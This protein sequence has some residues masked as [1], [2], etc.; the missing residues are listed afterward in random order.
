M[1]NILFTE[2]FVEKFDKIVESDPVKARWLLEQIEEF[3]KGKKE[4]DVTQLDE[5]GYSLNCENYRLLF[6][7][8]EN[9]TIFLT[10]VDI[11]NLFDLGTGDNDSK[12]KYSFA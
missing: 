9:K 7:I 1:S 2:P 4:D 6:H 12:K 11:M 10:I 5:Y 3:E 8:K